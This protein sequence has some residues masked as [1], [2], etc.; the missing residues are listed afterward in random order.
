MI[1]GI[2]GIITSLLLFTG[3]PKVPDKLGAGIVLETHFGGNSLL[4]SSR[5]FFTNTTVKLGEN[6]LVLK[7]R[8]TDHT[9]IIV[10]DPHSYNEKLRTI[11]LATALRPGTKVSFPIP[12]LS[13]EQILIINPLNLDDP[14]PPSF[15]TCCG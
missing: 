13:D 14:L 3:C 6:T 10:A 2:I 15:P 11:G 7:V 1:R 12:S 5:T 4:N 8:A 9:Y